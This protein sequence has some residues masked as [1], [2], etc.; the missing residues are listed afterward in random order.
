MQNPANGSF[1]DQKYSG[2]LDACSI[3]HV[4]KSQKV[5]S[6]YRIYDSLVDKFCLVIHNRAMSG[7]RSQSN[8]Y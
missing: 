4:R 3:I 5:D 7:S 8:V 6:V 1:H 2:C